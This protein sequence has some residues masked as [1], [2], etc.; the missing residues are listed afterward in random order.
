M[1]VFHHARLL[2]PR[3]GKYVRVVGKLIEF[4]GSFSLNIYDMK[5]IEDSNEITHH[6]LEAVYVHCLH[7]NPQQ[8]PGPA[9]FGGMGGMAGSFAPQSS[10]AQ[11]AFNPGANSSM[12]MDQGNALQDQVTAFIQQNQT[13]EGCFQGTITN[14][15][16]THGEQKVL[17]IL[18][19]LSTEGHIYTTIDD[20]HFQCT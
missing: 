8:Q 13:D 15:F 6:F 17:E 12:Q 10:M 14:A 7:T 11:P 9:S 18:N 1:A 19:H 16:A 4:G 5:P 20:Q 2:S 3:V